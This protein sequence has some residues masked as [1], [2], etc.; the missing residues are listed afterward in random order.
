MTKNVSKLSHLEL[1]MPPLSS[2]EAYNL[3][4]DPRAESQM[5][6]SDF[7]MIAG[8]AAYHFQLDP[9][10][11]DAERAVVSF[12]IMSG[13][14]EMDRG[15][16]MIAD[17][18][19]I[20][21]HGACDF[22]VRFTR[23]QIFVVD[24]D[25][26]AENER[27]VQS[28]TPEGLLWQRS[29]NLRGIVGFDRFQELSTYDLLYAGIAKVGDSYD[30]LIAKGHQA[31]MN[32][33]SNEPQ[34]AVGARVS[35]ETF[36]FLFRVEPL[37]IQTFSP[38]HEF[39]DDEDL[40]PS[41]E[42]KRIVADA[43]KAFVHLLRPRYNTVKFKQYPRGIDGLGESGLVRYGYSIGEALTFNTPMGRFRGGRHPITGAMTNYAD[44][45][46]VEGSNV[47]LSRSGIDFPE[48][49]A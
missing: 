35:G 32:I 5:R 33:L 12:S 27:L 14:Q 21:D 36:L 24:G 7:Y 6:K 15:S 43:E 45:I 8:K 22:F 30:R 16:L 26:V 17:L 28:F 4:D 29:R 44:V 39:S 34:R 31:R 42:N 46:F 18:P 49:D 10:L 9:E 38:E 11:S 25:S 20:S 3:M 40:D 19:F 47:D 2:Q 48:D 41:V 37:F 23:D 13:D 1:V